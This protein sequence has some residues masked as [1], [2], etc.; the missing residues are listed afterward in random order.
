MVLVCCCQYLFPSCSIATLNH[1]YDLNTTTA[2]LFIQYVGKPVFGLFSINF[3][4]QFQAQQKCLI[5]SLT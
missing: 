4:S 1:V 3:V 2:N 5:S